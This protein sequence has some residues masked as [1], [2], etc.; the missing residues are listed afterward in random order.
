[1]RSVVSSQSSV[2]PQCRVLPHSILS[3][4]QRVSKGAPPSVSLCTTATPR[5]PSHSM[6]DHAGLVAVPAR[7]WL[8]LNA[9]RRFQW[10]AGVRV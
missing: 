8:W 10:F 1:M 3:S 4:A 9:V 2:T 5:L 7:R 6:R